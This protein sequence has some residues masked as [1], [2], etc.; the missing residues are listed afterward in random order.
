MPL[1]DLLGQDLA[2]DRMLNMVARSR[3]PQTL[4]FAGPQG[5]GKNLAAVLLAQ[6]LSC[7]EPENGDACGRCPACIQIQRQLYPDLLHIAAENQQIKIK[8]VAE[9]QDFISYSPLVGEHRIVII[10]D[11]HKLNLTAA[12]ALLK[13][14]EEP[15]P[16]VIF[17]LLSHRH[18]LLLATILSRCLRLQFVSLPQSAVVEILQRLQDPVGDGVVLSAD[19]IRAAA[20]WSGGSMGRARFFLDA[21]NLIWGR[22]FIGK[23]SRLPKATILAALDLAEVTA[24]FEEREMVFFLLRS[25]LHDALLSAQGIGTKRESEVQISSA[26]WSAD[27]ELFAALGEAEILAVRQRLL[28]LEQAQGINVNI[29]LAFEAFFTAIISGTAGSNRG[30]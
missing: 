20:A 2:R 30:F 14:L 18:H 5:V 26:D 4:L 28:G 29:K 27:V 13:T 19:A 7:R 21:E 23:F 11:A 15:A 8:Q 10:E 24:Q 17:I 12:N 9:I 1:A 22:E 25:F 16:A 6:A 3:V